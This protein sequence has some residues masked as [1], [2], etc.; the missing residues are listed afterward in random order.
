MVKES[1][2]LET[3]T[4]YF[5][6]VIATE[7]N[8]FVMAY[9]AIDEY[10]K[11][12]SGTSKKGK[13]DIGWEGYSLKSNGKK[14]YCSVKSDS[15]YEPEDFNDPYFYEGFFIPE[16]YAMLKGL[17]FETASISILE[18]AYQKLV[19]KAKNVGQ[20]DYL[21]ITSENPDVAEVVF[22]EGTGEAYVQG[23]SQGKTTITAET[24]SGQKAVLQVEV[25]G[26]MPTKD[27]ALKAAEE[28]WRK[29]NATQLIVEPGDQSFY[30]DMDTYSW[31][32][33][34]YAADDLSKI[35][36]FYDEFG[37]NYEEK[38][39]AYEDPEEW[40]TIVVDICLD[41]MNQAEVQKKYE[42]SRDIYENGLWEQ[43]D[44]DDDNTNWEY[45]EYMENA[46]E[47]YE[48][49]YR[50][51]MCKN[52]VTAETYQKKHKSSKDYMNEGS[53]PFQTYYILLEKESGTLVFAA[54]EWYEM[55]EWL[56]GKK[57][58]K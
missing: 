45:E 32:L 58:L 19:L 30:D 21:R 3:E 50:Q 9:P 13:S 18:N 46:A 48:K 51:Y 24:K 16:D 23:K 27:E 44:L 5:F 35:E 47:K 54:E 52:P 34:W 7:S 6:E 37:D 12:I 15:F 41:G 31:W 43:V 4:D 29:E 36:M 28:T 42:Y 38:Q 8:Y 40:V 53:I 33:D 11:I 56:M 49:E 55:K 10:I 2:Y 39:Y 25:N 1:G 22:S 57:F 14:V 17:K 26:K 20:L